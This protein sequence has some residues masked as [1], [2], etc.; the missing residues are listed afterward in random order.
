[1]QRSCLKFFI[2]PL[3]IFTVGQVV[4]WVE[5][6]EVVLLVYGIWSPGLLQ[7]IPLSGPGFDV[8]LEEVNSVYSNNKTF[9]MRRVYIS[10]TEVAGCS[11]TG[12]YFDHISDYY[13]RATGNC[14]QCLY[15]LVNLGCGD[16]PMFAQLGREWNMLTISAGSTSFNVRDRALYPTTVSTC[17][18]Q[19]RPYTV[20][21]RKLCELFNWRTLAYV[22]DTSRTLPFPLQLYD[23]LT[24][25]VRLNATDVRLQLFPIPVAPSDAI[26]ADHLRKISQVARIV[27]L[28]GTPVLIRQ[29]MVWITVDLPEQAIGPIT[30]YRNDSMDEIALR[31]FPSLLQLILCYDRNAEA[32]RTLKD[33]FKQE[34]DVIY[35]YRYPENR[36]PTEFTTS[37]YILVKMI[38]NILNRSIVQG[39]DYFDGQI[40]AQQFLNHSYDAGPIGGIYVDSYESSV[41]FSY[42]GQPSTDS[43][44]ASAV[45][46]SRQPT[47]A[48]YA[49]LRIS[50]R[51]PPVRSD[52]SQHSCWNVSVD[53]IASLLLCG[54]SFF[55]VSPEAHHG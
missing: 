7:S 30:Y 47:T 20:M 26:I 28:S 31:A 14:S 55:S 48:G 11:D 43:G 4:N 2:N 32:D 27:F 39:F 15:I 35:G 38:A 17:P 52:L 3:I 36:Q 42:A 46:N 22:Y 34:A 40:L 33:H 6:L 49:I 18:F 44:G 54:G 45:E 5:G 24:S 13:Y 21:F 16:P 9:Q 1:M 8:A 23:I 53:W 29:I 10:S 12:A 19:F 50:R 25:F 51:R 37:S 41:P